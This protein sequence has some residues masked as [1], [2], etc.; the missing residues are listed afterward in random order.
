[1]NDPTDEM[2]MA[3]AEAWS[4]DADAAEAGGPRTGRDR[5]DIFAAAVE[6]AERVAG[7]MRDQ[8]R[9]PLAPS[10]PS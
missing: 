10:H 2:V 5:D 7:A 4:H 3:G 1:M 8:A 6:F 9:L